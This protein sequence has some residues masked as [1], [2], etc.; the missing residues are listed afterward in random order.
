M[1]VALA[2]VALAVGAGAVVAISV[3]D[4]RAGLIGLT[5]ALV[6][7]TLLVDPLPPPAML[8]VRIVGALLAVAILRA[9]APD[10]PGRTDAGTTFGWPAETLIAAAAALGGIGIAMA[11]DRPTG[12]TG[13]TPEVLVTA[14]ATALLT[15]GAAPALLGASGSRRAIGLVVLAQGVCLLRAGLA[16]TPGDLEQLAIVGLLLGCAAAGALLARG[17]DPRMD[18]A[19]DA[20]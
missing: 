4:L 14:T 7:G 10:E 13:V 16:G 3:R 19:E 18:P 11:I 6:G 15:L 2:T 20:A 17:A 8:G 9:V 12:A 5:V 1:N